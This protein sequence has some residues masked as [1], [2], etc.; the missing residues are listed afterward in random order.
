MHRRV[1][2]L[3]SFVGLVGCSLRDPFM[4]PETARIVGMLGLSAGIDGSGPCGSSKE[5][6]EAYLDEIG[7]DPRKPLVETVPR[8]ARRAA[9]LCPGSRPV[10]NTANEVDFAKVAPLLGG[11]AFNGEGRMQMEPGLWLRVSG[12]KVIGLELQLDRI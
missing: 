4:R 6:A 11:S 10:I 2:F 7:H 8:F 1:V 5:M 3:I 9:K 12:G